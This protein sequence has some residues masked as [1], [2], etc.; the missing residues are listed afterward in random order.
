MSSLSLSCMPKL[1]R[2][3]PASDSESNCDPIIQPLFNDKDK[4]ATIEELT[5]CRMENLME[6]WPGELEAKLRNMTVKLCH[7]LSNILF[8]SNSIKGMQNLEVLEVEDCRSIGVA[9]DL[10]GL[11]WEDGIS[12][13]ALPSLKKVEALPSL[14]KVELS[15]LRK[16]THVWKDNL[17]GIQGFQNLRSL[18]VNDCDSLRNLI[19]YSLAKLLVKLQEIEVTECGMMESIIGNEPNPDDAVITNRIMFP[20]LSSLKLSDLPNL[21]SFCS[22]ACTLE[23]SLLKTIEVSNCPKMKILPSAFQS[24]LE[25]QQKANFS[26][27]SQRHLLDGKVIL[28]WSSRYNKFGLIITD[29]NGSMEMWHNQLQVDYIYK[30]RFMLVQCCGKFSNVISSN[31]MQRLPRGLERLKVWWCDSLETIFDLQGSVRA[32]TTGA[33]RISRKFGGDLKLMYL[34]KLMH[35]WKNVSQQTHCFKYLKSLEVERCDNLRYI[36]TISMVKVLVCLNYLSIGNCEK[37]EMIVIRE[38]E[39]EEEDDDDH[40]DN[41]NNN[42][43]VELEEEGY[44]VDDDDDDSDDDNDFS[45]EL[46][47]LRS[48]N[49]FSVELENLPSLVCIGIPESQIRISKLRVNFCPKYQVVMMWKGSNIYHLLRCIANLFVEK[50]ML[51]LIKKLEK[52]I[53]ALC[54]NKL[55]LQG[56]LFLINTTWKDLLNFYE[57]QEA[58]EVDSSPIYAETSYNFT[59]F[60]IC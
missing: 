54:M 47:N 59:R 49:D 46:E 31:L 26:I 30:V 20:Q 41:D 35:I 52:E 38:E 32:G 57:D 16:L 4:L 7:G 37:I 42:F 40:D 45:V 27:S 53:L 29:I 6:I 50:G 48:L 23:G 22:E 17:P 10:E 51:F 34:P 25:Q 56:M 13:G 15:H 33:E 8:P 28:R 36:F 5:I 2:L 43:G 58:G 14:K 24:K 3:C 60:V 39:E 18:T 21:S 1:K 11:V 12:D 55:R 19:S 44:Y 9:F